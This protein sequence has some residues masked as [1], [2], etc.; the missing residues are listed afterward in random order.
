MELGV[1][2]FTEANGTV[3][4][5]VAVGEGR[6]CAW[7]T[8]SSRSMHTVMLGH[9][10]QISCACCIIIMVL[11]TSEIM[12]KCPAGLDSVNAEASGAGHPRTAGRPSRRKSTGLAQHPKIH[13]HRQLHRALRSTLH[14]TNRMLFYFCVIT[15]WWI[16]LAQAV[17][18]GGQQRSLTARISAGAISGGYVRMACKTRVVK[19]TPK[20]KKKITKR[21][22]RRRA[23]Q[24]KRQEPTAQERGDLRIGTWNTRQL[25]APSSAMDQ[26]YKLGH[27]IGL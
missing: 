2:S 5:G 10:V 27:M 24:P 21:S 26:E 6:D 14:S 7:A 3:G 23:F 16:Q 20:R 4:M 17:A 13:T 9:L 8:G 25:R 12:Q 11:Y 1:F 15:P 18:R 22:K 19:L